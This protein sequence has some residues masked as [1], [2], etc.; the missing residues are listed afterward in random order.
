MQLFNDASLKHAPIAVPSRGSGLIAKTI[1]T[2][3][4]RATLEAVVLDGFFPL[5]RGT[6]LPEE[7]R[8]TGLQE[9]GLPYASDPVVSKHLARFL[10]PWFESVQVWTTTFP[11]RTNLYF[12]AT[13]HRLPSETDLMMVERRPKKR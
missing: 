10:T 13:N 7:K 1:S 2:K 12:Y 6:D 5:T 9:F 11:N 8:G 4:D 3:L